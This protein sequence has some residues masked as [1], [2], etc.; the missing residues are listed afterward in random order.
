MKHDETCWFDAAKCRV[1]YETSRFYH[2]K[3][4]VLLLAGVLM[5]SDGEECKFE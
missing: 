1:D 3:H 4:V 5:L 2:E